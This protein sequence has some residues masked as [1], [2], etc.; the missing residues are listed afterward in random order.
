MANASLR[1]PLRS[2]FGVLIT[3]LHF[4]LLRDVFSGHFLRRRRGQSVPKCTFLSPWLAT[5]FYH[6]GWQLYGTGF[7]SVLQKLR[8]HLT[9]Q[10]RFCNI[11]QQ[12]T[13]ISAFMY[14]GTS[15]IDKILQVRI[16][17][18][19]NHIFTVFN[20]WGLS[21]KKQKVNISYY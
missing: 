6:P 19:L 8:F 4:H 7:C 18:N 13:F 16:Q 1:N 3:S 5:I 10:P 20:P 14:V 21:Q 17:T 9:P 2:W 11:T 12:T 15:S